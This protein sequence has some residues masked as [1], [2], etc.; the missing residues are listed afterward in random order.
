MNDSNGQL[1]LSFCY[2]YGEAEFNFK[3]VFSPVFQ[4]GM[5]Q[6]ILIESGEVDSF[7]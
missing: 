2:Y 1:L 6:G 4:M 5:A 3:K 7:Y